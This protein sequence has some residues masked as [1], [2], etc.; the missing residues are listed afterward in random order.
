MIISTWH[1]K[2]L[3][4]VRVGLVPTICRKIEQ[5]VT[6]RISETINFI[7]LCI[8]LI[9]T[10]KFQAV[11]TYRLSSDPYIYIYVYDQ[12]D[13]LYL[14]H[15]M[16]NFQPIYNTVQHVFSDKTYILFLNIFAFH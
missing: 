12:I 9:T 5:I 13:N 15:Y 11:T 7:L 16:R 3:R 14:T 1:S 10:H 2:Q 6:P 4:Y 8:H